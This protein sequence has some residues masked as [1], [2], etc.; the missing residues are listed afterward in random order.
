MTWRRCCSL[1]ALLLAAC[2][3]PPS[4]PEQPALLSNPGATAL[5]ELS[6]AAAAVSGFAPVTLAEQDFTLD[7]DVLLERRH[8]SNRQ[9]ELIQGRDLELPHRLRLL[10]QAGQCWLLDMQTG[11][12]RLLTQVRCQLK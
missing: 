9:G 2:Q 4:V 12:K 3:L 1:P 5:S 6:A 8:Q 7:S 10:K 11:Q